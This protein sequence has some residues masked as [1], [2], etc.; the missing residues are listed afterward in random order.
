MSRPPA[1]YEIAV[2]GGGPAG[3]TAALFAAR[4]GR[5]T[6]L[7]DPLG[8]GGAILNTERVEDFPGFPEGV[9]G[10]VLGPLI[11]EQFTHAGGVVELSEVRRIESR[12]DGW[13]VVTDGGEVVA[14]AV[15]VAHV[16]NLKPLKR[17]HDLVTAAHVIGDTVP[18][19]AFLVLG[20]GSEH[21]MLR[22]AVADLERGAD[23]HGKG[24]A[25]LIKPLVCTPR[26]GARVVVSNAGRVPPVL[27]PRH[28][29]GR[30]GPYIRP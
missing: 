17:A 22:Q 18:A 4:H 16:S 15:I 13:V 28:C 26:R 21:E 9:A 25:Y 23:Q 1:E 20:S 7:L 19:L 2:A 29:G 5:R 12:G 27:R 30:D 11:Q 6:I 14:G 3:L 8:L 10:Y 24:A